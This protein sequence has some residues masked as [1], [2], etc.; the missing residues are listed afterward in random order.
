MNYITSQPL[1]LCDCSSPPALTEYVRWL[2]GSRWRPA[3]LR[4]AQAACWTAVCRGCGAAASLR[5]PGAGRSSRRTSTGGPAQISQPQ[6]A[7]TWTNQRTCASSHLHDNITRRLRAY[8]YKWQ[9]S[10][11]DYLCSGSG[12]ILQPWALT[13]V[14]FWWQGEQW[15]HPLCRAEW[16]CRR[17]SGF[18]QQRSRLTGP[19][20]PWIFWRFLLWTTDEEQINV[21]YC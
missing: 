3:A 8:E 11:A 13:F 17:L 16:A 7:F 9:H 14:R 5:S 20:L 4:C 21:Y 12:L 2:W 6:I 10:F 15:G 19:A 18:S 1:N